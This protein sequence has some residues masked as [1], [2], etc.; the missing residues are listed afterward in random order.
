MPGLRYVIS[1]IDFESFAEVPSTINCVQ[2]DGAHIRLMRPSMRGSISN[3]ELGEIKRI[4]LTMHRD[5]AP[6]YTMGTLEPE[7]AKRVSDEIRHQTRNPCSFCGM[8]E[9]YSLLD[10]PDKFNICIFDNDN[11]LVVRMTD[12]EILGM[13]E[14]CHYTIKAQMVYRPIPRS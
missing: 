7:A 5:M 1:M 10:L 6:V 13:H 12:V 9:T 14:H 8:M 4:G 3:M 11:N 2:G